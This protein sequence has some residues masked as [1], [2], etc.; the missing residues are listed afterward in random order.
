MRSFAGTAACH[1]RSEP[2]QDVRAA[3]G[4]RAKT[5][6]YSSRSCCSVT[7]SPVADTPHA[8]RCRSA[9]RYVLPSRIASGWS[10]RPVRPPGWTG[11]SKVANCSISRAIR[12]AAADE[13]RDVAVGNALLVELE[14][15]IGDP[16]GLLELVVRGPD[17]RPRARR[18]SAGARSLPIVFSSRSGID[19]RERVGDVDDLRPAAAVG[20]DLE[21]G[22]RPVARPRRSR[23][24]RRP[25]RATGRSPA[26]RRR[27]RTARPSARRAARSAAPAPG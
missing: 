21:G 13:D 25:I 26:R 19:S 4:V 8:T 5:C 3:A 20:G 22:D 27:R 23:C 1:S 2:P 17:D 10:N 11:M 6:S 15:Q 18:P 14:D 7:C 24:C 9:R 12:R 16:A